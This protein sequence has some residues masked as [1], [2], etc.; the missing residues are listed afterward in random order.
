MAWSSPIWV[1][2]APR[3]PKKPVVKPVAKAVV[4][5]KDV[6]AVK[7]LLSA[8]D[9]DDEAD[10]DEDEDEVDIEEDDDDEEDDG[11]F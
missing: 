7:K 11:D 1:D 3:Q 5:P 9:E 2:C 10:D 4:K 8:L 6:K